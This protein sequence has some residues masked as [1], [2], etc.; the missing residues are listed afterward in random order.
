MYSQPVS[1]IN[2]LVTSYS[3]NR[4]ATINRSSH[5]DFETTNSISL[6]AQE[7]RYQAETERIELEKSRKKGKFAIALA[8]ITTRS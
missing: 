3:L 1:T 6:T 8:A 2:Q 4:V 5:I 7:Q